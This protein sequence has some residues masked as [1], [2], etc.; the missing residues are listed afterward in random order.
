M[1]M[2]NLQTEQTQEASRQSFDMG[3]EIGV[4]IRTS[5]EAI[6]E[7]QALLDDGIARVYGRLPDLGTDSDRVL[8]GILHGAI[9]KPV[10]E[11]SRKLKGDQHE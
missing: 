9:S 4:E 8:Q 11:I 5:L 6:P 2:A 7:A 10:S 1:S 3:K